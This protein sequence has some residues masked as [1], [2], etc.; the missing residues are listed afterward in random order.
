METRSIAS[1]QVLEKRPG[2]M[3][4]DCGAIMI[5]FYGSVIVDDVVVAATSARVSD[6]TCCCCYLIE[7]LQLGF[8]PSELTN[9]SSS[10]ETRGI[11]PSK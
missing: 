2:D 4:T 1:R 3:T 7:H 9:A 6:K 8:F 11:S 10:L 5:S